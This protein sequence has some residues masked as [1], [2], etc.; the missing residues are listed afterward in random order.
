[1]GPQPARVLVTGAGGFIGAHLVR[2]LL[3]RGHQVR[4]ADVKTLSEWEQRFDDAENLTLDLQYLTDCRLAVDGIDVVY[5][6]AA[7]MGGIGFIENHK[8]ECMLSVLISTHM[9]VAAREAGVGRFFYSSSACVYAADKQ[10]DP[11]NPFLTEPDA[12]PA[13]AE[14][15]Y[16]VTVSA[17]RPE[18]LEAA[19][20]DDGVFADGHAGRVDVV[21][22]HGRRR[23]GFHRLAREDR[24]FFGGD[25]E[26]EFG[27]EVAVAGLEADA[28]RHAGRGAFDEAGE[29]ACGLFV[30]LVL[31]QPREEEVAG[32]EQSEV[33]FVVDLGAGQEPRG[34]EVEE[35]G[36]DEQELGGLLEV[37]RLVEGGDVFDEFG[38]DAVERDLGDV[39]LVLADELQQQVE[40]PLEVVKPDVEAAFGLL[41]FVVPLGRERGSL[42]VGH[43]R[44]LRPGRRAPL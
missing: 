27:Q 4:A 22:A 23:F 36:G 1:M 24:Q 42:L 41:R 14:D 17:R 38:G 16:G 15:G 3:D 40:R 8:A 5:N 35:G 13:L 32:F 7:D 31:E 43:A 20:E 10:L 25:V 26:D 2:T 21:G 33:L 11:D 29:V 34:L 9:L 19:A 18:K 39:E 44:K 28:A 6:L 30:G 37:P 12:Y